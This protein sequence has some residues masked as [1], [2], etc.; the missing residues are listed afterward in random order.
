MDRTIPSFGIVLAEEKQG[1]KLFR[2]TLDKCEQKE[3]DEMWDIPRLYVA[4]CPSCD[5]EAEA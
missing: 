3:F 2:D 1:C 5:D 4:S